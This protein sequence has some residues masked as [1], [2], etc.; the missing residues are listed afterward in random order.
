MSDTLNIT[1]TATHPDP[2]PLD[3]EVVQNAIHAAITVLVVA[4]YPQSSIDFQAVASDAIDSGVRN[5]GATFDP[6]EEGS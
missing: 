2:A 5:A 6:I 1:I 4:G 3:Q